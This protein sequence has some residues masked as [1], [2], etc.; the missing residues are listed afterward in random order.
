MFMVNKSKS[1]E[2]V[3]H[4]ASNGELIL[5]M[6]KA[7]ERVDFI[8]HGYSNGVFET[9]DSRARYRIKNEK[10]VEIAEYKVWGKKK[11]FYESSLGYAMVFSLAPTKQ[12][13]LIEVPKEHEILGRS[14]KSAL[15][16]SGIEK[17]EVKFQPERVFAKVTT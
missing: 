5:V 8:V 9:G 4:P 3:V 17:M 13:I 14:I 10:T 1:V 12:D 15:R 7:T 11:S 6:D 16:K 2:V